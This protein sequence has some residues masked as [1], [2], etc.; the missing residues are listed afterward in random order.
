M[1]ILY[2]LP[3]A[4]CSVYCNK[5]GSFQTLSLGHSFGVAGGGQHAENKS[6]LL[7]CRTLLSYKIQK[8]ID[9]SRGLS[10]AFMFANTLCHQLVRI[11]SWSATSPHQELNETGCGEGKL[12]KYELIFYVDFAYVHVLFM[13]YHAIYQN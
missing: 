11:Q 6:C 4:T 12:S 13:I 5:F 1:H 9:N 8:S 10:S 2:A 7:L 3:L